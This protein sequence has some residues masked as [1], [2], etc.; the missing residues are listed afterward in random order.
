MSQSKRYIYVFLPSSSFL[1]PFAFYAAVRTGEGGSGPKKISDWLIIASS[2]IWPQPYSMAPRP[3]PTSQ[4][5]GAVGNH[6]KGM[7]GSSLIYNF[8]DTDYSKIEK[9][10]Y[11]RKKP[12]FS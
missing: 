5:A 6:E 1:A 8:T 9:I 11:I 4:L 10:E 7:V 12:S 3:R 2:A